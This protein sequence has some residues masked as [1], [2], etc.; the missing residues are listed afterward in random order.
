MGGR[1]WVESE[2]GEGSRFHAVLRLETA[3]EPAAEEEQRQAPKLAGVRVLVVD[4]NETN[5]LILNEYLTRWRMRPALAASGAEALELME[6][7]LDASDRFTLVLL[8]A[9]MPGMDGFSVAAEIRERP[10]LAGTPVMMLSSMDRQADL[11]RC[12]EAGVSLYLNKPVAQ[13]DLREAMG[14]VLGSGAPPEAPAGG[15][16]AKA[17][18]ARALRILLAEDNVVNQHLAARTLEKAGHTVE[19]ASNGREALSL[20][21]KGGFDLVLMDLQM[22]VMGGLDAVAAIR[23]KER[24][25]EARIPVIA[26]TAHAM[27]GDRERCLDAGMDAYVTKPVRAAELIA[28][29]ERIALGGSDYPQE[30][31]EG[32]EQPC[33]EIAHR[34]CSN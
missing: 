15:G 7:A 13:T 20:L 2:E 30:P 25:G 1:I 32:S 34:A 4:D 5:R 16:R 33:S 23:E 29:V 21:D 28:V 18:P 11:E 17:Q 10:G 6:G 22:P 14:R 24:P 12:R 3:A 27:K 19:V 8:D 31:P 26:L 9:Q